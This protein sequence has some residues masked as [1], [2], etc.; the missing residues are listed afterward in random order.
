[1]KVGTKLEMTGTWESCSGYE[2]GTTKETVE[3]LAF[4]GDRVLVKTQSG[5]LISAEAKWLRA[6]G[7]AQDDAKELI[8]DV[9]EELVENRGV[10]SQRNLERMTKYIQG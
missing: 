1:M 7:Q 5:Q 9:L 2:S 3:F 4:G 8:G 6:P 10:V